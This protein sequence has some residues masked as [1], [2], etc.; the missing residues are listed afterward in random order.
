MRSALSPQARGEAM[1]ELARLA[2]A[3][4]E[5]RGRVDQ[6]AAAARRAQAELAEAREALVA[7][8]RSAGA[9][10]PSAS[11]RAAAEKRLARAEQEAR[12]PW[13]ERVQG[14]ERAAQDAH[15]LVQLHAAENLGELVAELEED[16]EAAAAE[17]DQAAQAFLAAVARRAEAERALIATVALTRRMNPNDVS[18]SRADEA[19]RAVEALLAAGGETAPELR[20]ELVPA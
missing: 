20:R 6:T 5:M 10:G 16:G 2:H 9:E 3:E 19:R 1:V 15:R 4:Q 12:A 8:E 7:I 18:R 13:R 14:A 17:V 11:E